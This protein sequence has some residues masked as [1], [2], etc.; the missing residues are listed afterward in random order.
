MAPA[1]KLARNGCRSLDSTHAALRTV[2]QQ[3]GGPSRCIW[4]STVAPGC[5]QSSLQRRTSNT[6]RAL[7]V[8]VDRVRPHQRWTDWPKQLCMPS[9]SF[10]LSTSTNLFRLTICIKRSAYRSRSH[11]MPPRSCASR[12]NRPKSSEALAQFMTVSRHAGAVLL[13]TT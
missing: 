9:S 11:S 10:L 1:V 2:M 7:F 6:V 3:I 5:R 8:A 12:T 4:H 13:V